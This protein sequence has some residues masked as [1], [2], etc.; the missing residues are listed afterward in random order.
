VRNGVHLTLL[1]LLASAPAAADRLHLSG[2][3]VVETDSWRI[4]GD[5][6]EYETAQGTV[7][8]PRSMVLRVEKSEAPAQEPPI[9]EEAH[10][11][12]PQPSAAKTPEPASR[13]DTIRV[14]RELAEILTE[15]RSAL[16]R[17]DHQTASEYY[18][19]ALQISDP[20]LQVPR[21]GYA[22]AQMALHRDETALS[23]VLEGLARD[24]DEPALLELL[25]DLY[26]RRER[27]PD[28]LQAWQT[29]FDL[30]PND[31]LREKILKAQRELEAGRDF[32]FSTS[33]HFNMRY[34]RDVDAAL[35]REVT[36]YLERQYWVL[37]ERFRYSPS[38]PITVL[39]YPTRE[40][41]DVTQS[42]E[43]VGGIYDGK[44][45]VP[46]GGLRRL[47]PTAEAVLNHE[48]TH[49]VIHAKTHGRCPR[50][51]HEGLA[52][53]SED[54][55]LGRADQETIVKSL[56]GQDPS[57]WDR[58]GF[59]YP[60]AL[61]LTRSLEER[62]GFDGLVRVLELLGDGDSVEDALMTVYGASYEELCRD[63][64]EELREGGSR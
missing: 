1:L 26:N 62:K 43:W 27:V 47:N 53:I 2:G 35:S 15:A 36:E 30:L 18:E 49:A 44:I 46:L 42:P 11:E 34:D 21:I 39:L 5:R 63:W 50:W 12:K 38:Q 10:A 51:L 20:D 54:R 3:G 41:R 52:Q 57:K 55:Y 59:S 22:L 28:A 56:A 61:S 37:A 23:V 16:D 24:P 32:S 17:G 29:A 4:A 19:R 9:E 13:S 8:L 40:F 25:G 33:A 58:A 7:G 60:K 31:R 48:L 64:A 14:S 45:R 6:I